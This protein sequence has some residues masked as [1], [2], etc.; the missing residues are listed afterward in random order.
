[1]HSFLRC[2]HDK[3]EQAASGSQSNTPWQPA[4]AERGCGCRE[5]FSGYAGQN[6]LLEAAVTAGVGIAGESR[7]EEVVEL[8]SFTHC[9]SPERGIPGA[10]RVSGEAPGGR[11]AGGCARCLPGC[12]ERGRSRVS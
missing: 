1:M 7:V 2:N 9:E 3:E 5:V 6:A 10:R 11:A 12:R 8:V 4:A